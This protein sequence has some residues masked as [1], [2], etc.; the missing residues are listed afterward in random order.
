MI[1]F[2]SAGE[3]R[4]QPSNRY[5]ESS[6]DIGGTFDSYID[7]NLGSNELGCKRDDVDIIF[8]SNCPIC[9]AFVF[10]D[11]GICVGT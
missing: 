9:S 3:K 6:F 7:K 10:Y 1:I 4:V 5:F 8:K 11:F 2:T